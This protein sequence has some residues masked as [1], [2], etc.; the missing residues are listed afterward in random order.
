[1]RKPVILALALLLPWTGCGGDVE[2]VFDPPVDNDEPPHE[3]ELAEAD[4]DLPPPDPCAPLGEGSCFAHTGQGCIWIAVDGVPT[5]T[6]ELTNVRA[7]RTGLGLLGNHKS[8]EVLLRTELREATFEDLLGTPLGGIEL[9]ALMNNWIEI[10]NS[11]RTAAGQA[12]PRG[13]TASWW[14]THGCGNYGLIPKSFRFSYS[15][16]VCNMPYCHYHK[17]K[18][19]WS[20]CYLPG[21]T[22][23]YE[24]R[25]CY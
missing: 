7:C 13:G 8:D 4:T 9:E 14:C 10:E 17:Y 25:S 1:M 22:D 16:D 12:V 2:P 21:P 23:R 24:W 18:W 15:I 11:Y 3:G 20:Y 5:S 19:V 6:G